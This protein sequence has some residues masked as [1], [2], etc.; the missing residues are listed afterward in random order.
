MFDAMFGNKEEK[1]EV[2]CN[3]LEASVCRLAETACA[4]QKCI[5]QKILKPK[6]LI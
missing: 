6:G 3:F 5:L 2:E 1:K 4:G